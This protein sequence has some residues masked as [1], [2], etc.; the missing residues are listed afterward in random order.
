MKT[1][2]AIAKTTYFFASLFSTY[3]SLSRWKPQSSFSVPH[4]LAHSPHLMVYQVHFFILL[5]HMHQI[6][7]RTEEK[8]WDSFW[9]EQESCRCIPSPFLST[10]PSETQTATWLQGCSICF[11]LWLESPL[12]FP[13]N[14][15]QSFVHSNIYR[16]PIMCTGNIVLDKEDKVPTLIKYV[17]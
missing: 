13:A 2:A 4:S 10:H 8:V 12:I 14:M 17:L 1:A 5:L 9:E 11:L 15:I 7:L 3:T 6:D 16:V